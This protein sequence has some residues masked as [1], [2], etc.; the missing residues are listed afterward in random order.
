M[1][2]LVIFADSYLTAVTTV[3]DL[4]VP[5]SR[6]LYITMDNWLSLQG[7]RGFPYLILNGARISSEMFGF[8]SERGAYQI[9]IPEVDGWLSDASRD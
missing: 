4:Y 3:N 9:S 8:L 1:S 7:M 5:A 2:K 6:W